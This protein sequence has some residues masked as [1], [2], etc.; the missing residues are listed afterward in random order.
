MDGN[1]GVYIVN[2]ENAK[3]SMYAFSQS[4]YFIKIE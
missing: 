1:F 3:N 2:E 4:V